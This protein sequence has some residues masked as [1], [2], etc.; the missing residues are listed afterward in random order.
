MKWRLFELVYGE[1]TR[2]T[3]GDFET[4]HTPH[5]PTPKLSDEDYMALS[6][7]LREE[8]LLARRIL[9]RLVEMEAAE[10]WMLGAQA[11]TLEDLIQS[12]RRVVPRRSRET[13]DQYEARIFRIVEN[14]RHRIGMGGV[15]PP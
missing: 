4:L 7:F 1:T 9:L 3:A 11:E 10:R 8:L 6:G 15:A 14:F 12:L 2:N 5:T 13:P